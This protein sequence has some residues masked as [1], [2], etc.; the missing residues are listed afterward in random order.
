M[1][2]SQSINK[3]NFEDIQMAHKHLDSYFIINTLP[4]S[5]Q[6]CLIKNTVDATLEEQLINQY[7][8]S[9]YEIKILIYGKHSND[10][11]VYVKHSQLIKLG[12]T[13]IYVYSGG[14]FEWLL[15]Q[16][17]YGT[18]EFPTTS[19][20]TDHLKYKPSPLLQSFLGENWQKPQLNS[21]QKFIQ[22]YF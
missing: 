5:E 22:N 20:Q 13:N 16:D 12:F 7:I 14:L 2:N 4:I 10:E 18:S 8:K 21:G 11:S 17:I 3:I 1:G 6:N 9:N 19:K 15:L